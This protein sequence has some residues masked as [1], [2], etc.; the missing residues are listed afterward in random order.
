MRVIVTG[1]FHRRGGQGASLGIMRRSTFHG[2]GGGMPPPQY[3]E[4]QPIPSFKV[5]LPADAAGAQ[6]PGPRATI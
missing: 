2:L 4:T 3:A 5:F 6:P 1:G